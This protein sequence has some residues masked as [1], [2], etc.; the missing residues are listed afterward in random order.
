MTLLAPEAL[1]GVAYLVSNSLYDV[2]F[3]IAFSELENWMVVKLGKEKAGF[4]P[5]HVGTYR[6]TVFRWHA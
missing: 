6:I 5:L 3:Q 4:I 2:L 1:V